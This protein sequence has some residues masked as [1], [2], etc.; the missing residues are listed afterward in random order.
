[1]FQ[2]R[3]NTPD[4][5]DESGGFDNIKI[6]AKFNCVTPTANPTLRPT[7]AGCTP[8]LLIHSENFE[9]GSLVGWT[10]GKIESAPTFTK[11]LGR[12]GKSNSGPG[13][14]PFKYYTDIPR[15]AASVELKF[16]FYEIDSW[17][18]RH[19]DYACV[20]V[21]G[22][23]IDLGRFDMNVNEDGRTG[24]RH[25]MTFK[26]DSKAPPRHIGFNGRFLDQIHCVT[27]TIPPSFYADGRLKIMFQVRLNTP[28]INDESGGFD[29]I[30]ITAN[31][32]CGRRLGAPEELE[33][34]NLDEAAISGF[35][36][37]EDE[38]FTAPFVEEDELSSSVLGQAIET[39][40]RRMLRG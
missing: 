1:M 31:F 27:V 8:E 7:P 32:N 23:L 9:D 15:N 39:A 28:D 21:D 4:I 3:L 25:G 26:I 2:V 37:E 17:D 16:D 30:R 5:N 38:D 12:Y 22:K 14:D 19:R 24:S 10:N 35:Y 11:F 29:N 36:Q 40:V 18:A 6:T 33:A 13:K 34:D 20:V